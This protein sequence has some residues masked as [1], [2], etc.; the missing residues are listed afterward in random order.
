MPDLLTAV[1]ILAD[2]TVEIAAASVGETSLVKAVRQI[3]EDGKSLDSTPEAS[4]DVKAEEGSEEA[5][6]VNEE[7]QKSAEVPTVEEVAD[8]EDAGNPAVEVVIKEET[9]A[10]AASQEE[11]E[12]AVASLTEEPATSAPTV[13][14]VGEVQ[15]EDQAPEEAVSSTEASP[16][17]AAP[18]EEVTTTAEDAPVEEETLVVET[19]VEEVEA[20]ETLEAVSTYTE[21][22]AV[23]GATQLAAASAGSDL[24]V[25]SAAEPES[26][27]EAPVQEAK[28]CHSCHSAPST[29]EEVAPPAAVGGQLE[30][31][32]VSEGVVD[33][34][35]EA[36]EE[37][38]LVEGQSKITLTE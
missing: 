7:E 36:K 11:E 17:D 19:S 35:H 9:S 12:E 24:E 1:Q 37:V 33:I 16:E 20:E 14:E 25:L 34:T 10:P 22:A 8:T 23:V 30:V 2:S 38:S 3:E 5:A 6:V 27:S 4:T 29:G 28:H 15:A 21:R 18:A 13:E 32:L 26:T 31:Q